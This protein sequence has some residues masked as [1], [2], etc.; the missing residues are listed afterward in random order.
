MN[1][2]FHATSKLARSIRLIASPLLRNPLE[3]P[4]TESTFSP[5][6]GRR[7]RSQDPSAVDDRSLRSRLGEGRIFV[8]GEGIENREKCLIAAIAHGDNCIAADSVSLGASHSGVTELLAK[9]VG[10]KLSQPFES[11][12]D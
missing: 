10:R 5:S 6:R 9:F 8:I 12:I 1:R 3:R 11:R 2:E 7:E 4:R